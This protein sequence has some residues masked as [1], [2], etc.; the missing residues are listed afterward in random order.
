MNDLEFQT[1][2]KRLREV[3]P[4]LYGSKE[5]MET[6]WRFVGDMDEKWFR[7]FVDNVVASSNPRDEKYD[8]GQAAIGEKRARKSLEF[9]ENIV[10]LSEIAAGR[11]SEK[12]LEN[13]LDKYGVSNLFEAVQKSRKGEV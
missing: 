7:N 3:H 1:Q 5:K 13:I 2:Y 11:I 6:I 10:R 9:S 4:N 8:I 12:G